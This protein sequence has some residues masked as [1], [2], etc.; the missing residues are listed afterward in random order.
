MTE[1]LIAILCLKITL[2]NFFS[3]FLMNFAAKPLYD[4]ILKRSTHLLYAQNKKMNNKSDHTFSK[5]QGI[6]LRQKP[7]NSDARVVINLS[8]RYHALLSTNRQL[9]CT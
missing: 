9:S 7:N 1:P 3:K 8:Q 6:K 5:L 4:V 2:F